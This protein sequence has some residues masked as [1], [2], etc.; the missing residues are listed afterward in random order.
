MIY[1]H[2]LTTFTVVR[3]ELCLLNMFKKYLGSEDM[4]FGFKKNVGTNHAIFSVCKV[5]NYFTEND[6]T[7][8][9]C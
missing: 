6:S 3:I 1:S 2:N 9:L 4:Q 5:V 7:V 8:K